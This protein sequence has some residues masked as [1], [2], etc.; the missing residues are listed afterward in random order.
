MASH[1][2]NVMRAVLQSLKAEVTPNVVMATHTD[3]TELA[4]LPAFIL[5][6]PSLP[7]YRPNEANEERKERNP[8]GKTM[9]IRP[10]KLF[11]DLEFEVEILGEAI[12]GDGGIAQIQTSFLVW[13]Q[14]HSTITVDDNEYELHG[15]VETRPQ[16]RQSNN[17]NLKRLM[18]GFR[19]EGVEIDTGESK[20]GYIV[21][22]GGRTYGFH[23]ID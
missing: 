3:Y 17:S 18:G 12:T 14:K 7:D 2:E 20:Q 11:K 21:L 9:T 16:G 23:R 8:D 15:D 6:Y 10:P 13:M 19:I 1:I 4:E 22:P 5:Y